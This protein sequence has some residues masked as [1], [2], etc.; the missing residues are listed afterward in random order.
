MNIYHQFNP[1]YII[2]RGIHHYLMELLKSIA[3]DSTPTLAELLRFALLS[4][5]NSLKHLLLLY[6]LN[7]LLFT[8]IRLLTI[9]KIISPFKK[10]QKFKATY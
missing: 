7:L 9:N 3:I 1:P 6:P 2:S 8:L 4:L 5:L 10:K